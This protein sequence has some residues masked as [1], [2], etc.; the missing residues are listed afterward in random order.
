MDKTSFP[1]LKHGLIVV[2]P[3][4]G[5]EDEEGGIFRI[6]M[7]KHG[8]SSCIASPRRDVGRRWDLPCRRH[9]T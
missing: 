8:A 4:R 6:P 1:K 9:D 5:V 7:L 3:L 2:T